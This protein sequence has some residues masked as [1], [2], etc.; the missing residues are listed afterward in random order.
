MLGFFSLRF[1][2]ISLYLNNKYKAN[3]A[4]L[5]SEQMHCHIRAQH[6]PHKRPELLCT[7]QVRN[8]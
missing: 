5:L 8:K 6:K 1:I 7:I 4:L 2:Q 3:I